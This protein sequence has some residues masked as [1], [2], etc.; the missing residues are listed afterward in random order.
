MSTQPYLRAA[1]DGTYELLVPSRGSVHI[2]PYC[3]YTEDDAA[4][5]LASRKGREQIQ[6]IHVKCEKTGRVSRRYAPQT[7]S[8]MP[9]ALT[10]LCSLVAAANS[11][12]YRTAVWK[13]AIKHLSIRADQGGS[14]RILTLC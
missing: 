7:Q 11:S 6:Q 4:N 13:H 1:D 14:A 9:Y 10:A 5:W 3:F 8:A 2:L 12:T